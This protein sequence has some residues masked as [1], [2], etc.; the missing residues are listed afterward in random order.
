MADY[1]FNDTVT[2]TVPTEK[3]FAFPI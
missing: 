2:Y 1:I 3:S